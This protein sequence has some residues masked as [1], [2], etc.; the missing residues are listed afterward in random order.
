MRK[1][2]IPDRSHIKDRSISPYFGDIY[3]GET[4]FRKV[5]NHVHTMVKAN[6]TQAVMAADAPKSMRGEP[7]PFWAIN[8]DELM[9]STQRVEEIRKSEPELIKTSSLDL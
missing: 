7:T 1:R 4:F 6:A 2:H 3:P 9:L 5:I 8:P